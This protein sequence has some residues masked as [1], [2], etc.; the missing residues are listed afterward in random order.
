MEYYAVW[1]KKV[2]G[3]TSVCVCPGGQPPSLDQLVNA[4]LGETP[5]DHQHRSGEATLPQVTMVSNPGLQPHTLPGQWRSAYKKKILQNLKDFII[6]FE[7]EVVAPYLA[8]EHTLAEWQDYVNTLAEWQDYVITQ[9]VYSSVLYHT[10]S[11]WPCDVTFILFDLV[12]SHSL[13]LTLWCHTHSVWPCDVTL[14]LVDLVMSHINDLWITVPLWAELG[15]G[16]YLLLKEERKS[17]EKWIEMFCWKCST[18]SRGGRK[19]IWLLFSRC[20]LPCS[21]AN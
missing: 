8:C 2:W 11:V 6:M 15:M 4:L 9:T 20:L 7:S 16:K 12:M 14:I 1:R 3:F 18:M 5:G 10:H 13:C 17:K 21:C 19:R